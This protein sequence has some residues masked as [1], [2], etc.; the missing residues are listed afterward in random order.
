MIFYTQGVSPL[1]SGYARTH[2]A[3]RLGELRRAKDR[4][5]A[6]HGF[7]II[8]ANSNPAHVGSTVLDSVG[9]RDEPPRYLPTG[10]SMKWQHADIVCGAERSPEDEPRRSVST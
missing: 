2:I 5:P 3:L 4:V 6:P 10:K 8:E 1:E 9:A 7:I